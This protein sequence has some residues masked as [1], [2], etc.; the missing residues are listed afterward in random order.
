MAD[1]WVVWPSSQL[2]L[3]K[4]RPPFLFICIQKSERYIWIKVGLYHF[5]SIFHLMFKFQACT[6]FILKNIVKMINEILKKRSSC[7]ALAQSPYQYV[8]CI[9]IHYTFV[10]SMKIIFYIRSLYHNWSTV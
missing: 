9:M 3:S 7:R 4:A 6:F 8:I 1:Y 2:S 5:A 10:S